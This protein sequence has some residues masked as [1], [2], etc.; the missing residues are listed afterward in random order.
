MAGIIDVA[1]RV[2]AE[3]LSDSDESQDVAFV[4][5]MT[6][7][8]MT[9]RKLREDFTLHKRPRRRVTV[10][11]TSPPTPK[12]PRVADPSK[13][14]GIKVVN[15]SLQ[16]V[17]KS[18]TEKYEERPPE[19]I[20]L[21]IDWATAKQNLVRKV[22]PKSLNDYLKNHKDERLLT[23]EEVAKLSRELKALEEKRR[24]SIKNQ[25]TPD[26]AKGATGTFTTR[27]PMKTKKKVR[28]LSKYMSV[29]DY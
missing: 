24:E 28:I 4:R 10:K 23:G 26:W 29:N 7:F 14:V 25:K 19:P 8:Q 13:V 18:R 11:E 17:R 22:P 6:S 1:D 15:S 27:L 21:P 20:R 3:N 2:P 16:F 12:S 5:H 9:A